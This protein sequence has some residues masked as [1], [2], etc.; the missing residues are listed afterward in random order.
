MLLR[1]LAVVWRGLMIATL[2]LSASVPARA[3]EITQVLDR[4]L[5]SPHAMLRD[6][7][8]SWNRMV[9]GVRTAENRFSS[10]ENLALD[11]ILMQIQSGLPS[12]A[13]RG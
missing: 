10:D 2:L 9:E 6:L 5:P 1:L 8:K 11:A 4:A 3:H 13:A 12:I 7:A